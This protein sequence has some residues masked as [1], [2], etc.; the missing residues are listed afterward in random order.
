MTGAGVAGGVAAAGVVASPGGD[1]AGAATAGAS[2]AGCAAT[3][4]GAAVWAFCA[5]AGEV[6]RSRLAAAI[7]VSEQSERSSLCVMLVKLAMCQ[8]VS[9]VFGELT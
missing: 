4:G 6:D 2:G 1:G 9:S 8:V 3:T 5:S 7:A